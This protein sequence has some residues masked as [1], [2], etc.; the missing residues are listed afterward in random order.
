MFCWSS[1]SDHLASQYSERI[2]DAW[3]MMRAEKSRTAST[4]PMYCRYRPYT[5]P[6]MAPT[7]WC[8]FTTSFNVAI[9]FL[10][11][12]MD[13]IRHHQLI[14][15]AFVAEISLRSLQKIFIFIVKKYFY[16]VKVSKKKIKL[17]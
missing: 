14:S 6:D 7:S 16:R 8:S 9:D 10:H 5:A 3:P 11:P 15:D 17:I 13:M 12:G 2:Q 4:R 1:D